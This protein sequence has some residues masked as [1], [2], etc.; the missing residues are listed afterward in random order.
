MR[1]KYK[2]NTENLARKFSTLIRNAEKMKPALERIQSNMLQRY[3]A[4]FVEQCHNT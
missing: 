3:S 4:E 2:V 1:L